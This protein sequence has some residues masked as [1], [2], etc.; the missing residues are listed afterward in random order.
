ML[1]LRVIHVVAVAEDILNAAKI[2]RDLR[3]EPG[4][5]ADIDVADNRAAGDKRSHGRAEVRRH[6]LTDLRAAET[7]A[8]SMHHA[9]GEGSLILLRV[10]LIA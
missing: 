2:R 8:E 4:K 10:E 1:S 9:R 5:A 7:E 3:P 6:V